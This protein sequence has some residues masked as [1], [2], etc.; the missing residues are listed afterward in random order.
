MIEEENEKIPLCPVCLEI[1]TTNL[2]FTS[3]NHLYHRNC[4]DKSNFK[5]PISGQV[6]SHYIPVNKV[7][8]GK[9]F[10]ENNF[11]NVFE[12][13]IYDLDGFIQDGF[14]RKGL[15]RNG[16]NINGIDERG[17][18]RNGELACG[19]KVEQ[20]FRE[21]AWNIYHASAEF[22]NKHKIMLECVKADPNTYE[23]ANLLLKNK[24]ID[25]AIFF[26]ERGGSFSL[27]SKHLRY[28][29]QVGMVAVKI[30]PNNFQYLDKN[31]K[32]DDEIF[33]LAFQQ[34]EEILRYA[35]ERLRKKKQ[36]PLNTTT[37][38]FSN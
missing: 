8:I 18:I 22:R 23:Y 4:F 11:E 31:L 12:T 2:H 10:F 21:N 37:F 34:N 33:K 28:I 6:F 25:L 19:E 17:F 20:S 5:S 16:F 13:I 14:N 27:I 9:V 1:L 36:G 24:N 38:K 15:D 35:S 7:F 32:D 30:I 3:D 29:K 26:L